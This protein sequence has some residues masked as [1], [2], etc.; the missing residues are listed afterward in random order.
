VLIVLVNA[1][2]AAATI[3]R[4]NEHVDRAAAVRG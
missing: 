4:L 1:S 3:A 2:N